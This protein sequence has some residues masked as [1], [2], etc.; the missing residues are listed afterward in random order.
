[1]HIR[2]KKLGVFFFIKGYFVYKYI[3]IKMYGL[4]IFSIDEYNL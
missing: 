1:M 4:V 3:A 2:I